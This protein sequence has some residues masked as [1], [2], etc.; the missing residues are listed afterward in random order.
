MET[1]LLLIELGT[2]GGFSDAAR[3]RGYP[4]PNPEAVLRGGDTLVVVGT[5]DGIENLRQIID[6]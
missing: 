6:D 5:P 1:G 2:S 4:S 3:R